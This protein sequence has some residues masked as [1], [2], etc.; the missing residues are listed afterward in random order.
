MYALLLTSTRFITLFLDLNITDADPMFSQ[1]ASMLRLRHHCRNFQTAKI[2]TQ[3]LITV[4]FL[5]NLSDLRRF[6]SHRPP[7][8]TCTHLWQLIATLLTLLYI[9]L[10]NPKPALLFRLVV[11]SLNVHMYRRAHPVHRIF[12][13]C[14]VIVV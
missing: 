10:V 3:G 9:I 14:Q 11:F 12:R 4:T 7:V 2:K 13:F 6:H 5:Y 1:L 8:G